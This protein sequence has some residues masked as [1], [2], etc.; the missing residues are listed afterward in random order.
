[1]AEI[2]LMEPPE[3]QVRTL[4]NPP[5]S[6]GGIVPCGIATTAIALIVVSL[7]IFTR[8][9]VVKGVLGID[10]YLC[11]AGMCFSFIFLGISLTLLNLGAGNHSWDVPAKTFIPKFWQTCIGATLTYAAAISLSKLS[12]LTFYLRISPDKWVRRIVHVLIALV[13]SYMV[14][15]TM[16]AVFR[17]RPVSSGWDLT[18][19]GKCIDLKTLIIFLLAT[20]V[21]VDVFVLFLPFRIVQPLQ[22]PKRQKFGL[23]ILFATAGAILV[24]TIKRVAIC[25]PIINSPDYT[26]YLPKQLLLSFIEVNTSLV[27]VS[28]PALKPFFMKYIP[29][30]VQ[31]R[32]RSR[33]KSSGN[34]PSANTPAQSQDK[35]K[36]V[37]VKDESYELSE[38]RDIFDERNPQDDE[39]CLW[40]VGANTRHSVSEGRDTDSNESLSDRVSSVPAD[41]DTS[42]TGFSA[43]RCQSVNG[44]QITRET[45]V[46]YGPKDV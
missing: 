3:G 5:S 30:L 29:F 46:S 1:M 39:A 43:T 14:V 9:I 10:D 7:R 21:T 19:E 20:T 16:L 23:A 18:I 22:I 44:I 13:C 25:L 4:V 31:S 24:V 45:V 41:V 12:V 35:Q 11:M 40:P 6:A 28:V 42:Q 33:A 36:T 26:W 2:Y 37:I 32:L 38:R 15:Y 8:K 17:C 27:C 34:A